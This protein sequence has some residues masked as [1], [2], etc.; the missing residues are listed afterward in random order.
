MT[1]VR[2]LIQLLKGSP[3]SSRF[4]ATAF[5]SLREMRA[6]CPMERALSF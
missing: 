4:A 3:R 1:K 5:Q 2:G 6:S